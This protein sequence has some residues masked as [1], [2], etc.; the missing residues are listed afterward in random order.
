MGWVCWMELRE[1]PSEVSKESEAQQRD[2]ATQHRNPLERNEWEMTAKR[3]SAE[4]RG[5]YE[6]DSDEQPGKVSVSGGSR[7]K[8]ERQQ[9]HKVKRLRSAALQQHRLISVL[10]HHRW[11]TC[12]CVVMKFTRTHELV[13]VWHKSRSCSSVSWGVSD[14]W[15]NSI[16]CW[17]TVSRLLLFS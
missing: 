9:S 1:S 4:W 10:L 14:A 13:R 5:S 16:F 15:L 2:E 7:L 8:T 6:P 12:T 17:L 3:K 11:F